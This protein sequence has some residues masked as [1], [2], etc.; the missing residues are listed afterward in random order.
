MQYFCDKFIR[1]STYSTY[2]ILSVLFYLL[3]SGFCLSL[4]QLLSAKGRVQPRIP[5]LVTVVMLF[6]FYFC[7]IFFLMSQFA[8]YWVKVEPRRRSLSESSGALTVAFWVDSF[9]FKRTSLIGS[10]TNVSFWC[11]VSLSHPPSL[12]PTCTSESQA[13]QSARVAG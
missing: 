4:S 9:P 8:P 5:S 7:P 2:S 1:P 13:T 12:I 10:R 3:H 6:Y 11:H